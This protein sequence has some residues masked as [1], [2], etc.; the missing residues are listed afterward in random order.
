MTE[1]NIY[2]AIAELDSHLTLGLKFLVC[3]VL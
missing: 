3:L 1:K 2:N